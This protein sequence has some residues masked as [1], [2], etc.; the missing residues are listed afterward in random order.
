MYLLENNK[1]AKSLDA[2]NAIAKNIKNLI[3]T[4]ADNAT[5]EAA[6]VLFNASE[7]ATV[8]ESL[9]VLDFTPIKGIGDKYAEKLVANKLAII[10]KLVKLGEYS[11]GKKPSSPLINRNKISFNQEWDPNQAPSLMFI[12]EETVVI[13]GELARFFR[14]QGWNPETD[15]FVFN[16]FIN[17]SEKEHPNRRVQMQL[18]A[19]KKFTHNGIKIGGRNFK[20]LFHGPNAARKDEILFCVE[21]YINKARE[22]ATLGTWNKGKNTAAKQAGRAGLTIGGT[23]PL[24]AWLGGYEISPRNICIVPSFQELFENV[25]TDYVDSETGEVKLN[26]LKDVILNAFDG[27]GMMHISKAK[28]D[29]LRHTLSQ[30]MFDALIKALKKMPSFTIRGGGTKGLI[31]TEVDFHEIL[32]LLGVTEIEDKWGTKHPIDEIIMLIDESVLKLSVGKNGQFESY[33]EYCDAFEHYKHTFQVMLVEHQD[34]PHNL[35]FQQLQ[36]CIGASIDTLRPAIEKEVATI[37][38]FSTPEKAARLLGGDLAKIVNLVPEMHKL[39]WIKTREQQAYDKYVREAKAGVLHKTTHNVFCAPDFVAFL[40]WAAFRD[41]AKVTGFIKARS[42]MCKVLKKDK[43]VVSRNP[44]TDAQ[45][46]CPVD[47]MHDAGEWEKFVR[48]TTICFMSIHSLEI[49][50]VRGDYDGDHLCVSDVEALVAAA[51]EANAFTGGRLIDWSDVT[52]DKEFLDESKMADYFYSLTKTSQ[53]GHFCDQL[54]SL[55]GFGPRGY[56]HEVACWLVMAVNVFVDASKH[57]MGDVAIPEFVVNFLSL[58]DENGEVI[59]D[60][61]NRPVQRPLPVYAMQAKDNHNMS[62]KEKRVGGKRCAKKLGAGNGDQVR[63]NVELNCKQ[64]LT[65]DMAGIDANFN[66]ADLMIDFKGEHNNRNTFGLRG[67]EALFASGKYNEATGEYENE[68]LWKKLCYSRSKHLKELVGGMSDEDV[69]IRDAAQKAYKTR[70]RALAIF[71]LTQW[72]KE[73]NK[74]IE[75]VYDAATFYTWVSMKYPVIRKNETEEKLA[76]RINNYTLCVEA[77]CDIFGG[78]ALRAIYARN[79]YILTG[80]VIETFEDQL[81]DVT[82]DL[83]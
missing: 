82:N 34:K 6:S 7:D 38:G 71:A 32:K 69:Y 79:Q 83:F 65:V 1:F 37:N 30:D 44:S 33:E 29:E 25:P 80:G 39:Q 56:N 5:V 74:T 57:G 55:V 54:T 42:V 63:L 3:P 70:N 13:E 75:E 8:F 17:G 76:A 10:G 12:K 23:T 28:L 81:D 24:S 15:M 67:C 62:A 60:E 18:A 61:Y 73:N 59:V 64:V 21:E 68:G 66:V 22:F 45:A 48:Y 19:W 27:Y 14:E 47:V 43:G 2:I 40:Q 50:R 77:W 35:P 49:M 51:E 4:M 53:L 41:A 9:N 31:V 78:M 20:P 72:A 58:K 26:I 52:S 36:S 11:L 16:S 46:Q